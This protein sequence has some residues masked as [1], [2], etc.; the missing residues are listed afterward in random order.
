MVHA[1]DAT[2]V[3]AATAPFN[4]IRKVEVNLNNGFSPYVVDGNDL[5]FLNKIQA[6]GA[7]VTPINGAAATIAAVRNKNVLGTD[8]DTAANGGADNRFQMIVELP[9]TLNDRDPAGLIMLQANDVLVNVN[10]TL[11][12]ASAFIAAPAGYTAT[13]T[14]ATIQPIIETFSIPSIDDAVPDVSIMKLVHSRSEAIPGAGRMQVNLPTGNMYRKL[15][16]WLRD[17][18]GV[19]MTDAAINTD[20][21]ISFNTADRPY[22]IPHRVIAEQNLQDYGVILPNGLFVFDF[23][24]NSGIPNFGSARDY[25]DTAQLTEMALTFTAP[26]AGTVQYCYETISVLKG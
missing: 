24:R 22:V 10:V 26:A 1:A 18:A 16:V 14:S 2:F 4:I 17:A 11:G 8:V 5:Y 13:I 9:L 6:N 12:N 23:S 3:P 15:L 20:F 19:G 7:M 25:I 21:E